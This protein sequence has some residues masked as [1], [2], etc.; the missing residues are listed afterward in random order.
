MIE[1][2]CDRVYP[3]YQDAY[4]EPLYRDQTTSWQSLVKCPLRTI[5]PIWLELYDYI[6]HKIRKEML[7]S[8]Y[9]T[10][11]FYQGQRL[12]DRDAGYRSYS[13][14]AGMG[15]NM[16]GILSK[17]ESSVVSQTHLA[18]NSPQQHQRRPLSR[19]LSSEN[20]LWPQ[21]PDFS[22]PWQSSCPSST[23]LPPRPPTTFTPR[24][25]LR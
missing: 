22:L 20:Q 23:V 2:H 1:S 21:S 17:V 4:Q 18:T 10:V 24:S 13:T 11:E 3:N 5:V 12:R 8:V 6:L 15:I 9:H 25:W 16:D 7:G 14:E 19:V